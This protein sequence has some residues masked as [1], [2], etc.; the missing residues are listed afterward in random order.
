M[1]RKFIALITATLLALSPFCLCCTALSDFSGY[2]AV[3]TPEELCRLMKNSSEWGGSFYLTADIDLSGSAGQNPIGTDAAHPFTGIFDG[4]GHTVKGLDIKASPAAGLFGCISGAQIRNLTVQG[5]VA[6]TFEAQNA[7]TKADGSYPGSGA[8]AGIV[9]TG[10]VIENCVSRAGVSAPGNCGGLIGVIYNYGDFS[11]KV[12]DCSNYG[13]VNTTLG[14]A[15]ALIGRIQAACTAA[16]AVSVEGCTN[17]ADITSLSPDR[18]RVGGI[19]GYVRA[20]KG[21]I[22]IADC[23]NYGSISGSN[24]AT[25]ASHYPYAGGITGRIEIVSDVSSSVTVSGC[26]NRGKITSSEIAG[27]ITAYISCGKTCI[28]SVSGI[29]GCCNTA[30]VS[31]PYTA[32]GIAGLT[33]NQNTDTENRVTVKNCMNCGDISS[34]DSAG[35]I[36]GVN[37]AVD[38]IYCFDSSAVTASGLAGYIEGKADGINSYVITGCYAVSGAAGLALSGYPGI[39][40]VLSDAKL[41]SPAEA[42]L[43]AT[44]SGYD[45]NGVWKIENGVPVLS[46]FSSSAPA[47]TTSPA[48]TSPQAVPG[49]VE[50]DRQSPVTG[51]AVP[52]IIAAAT[53]AAACQAIIIGKKPKSTEFHGSQL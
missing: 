7:E 22:V 39:A 9:L 18:C 2:T 11:V 49:T 52:F 33:A 30:E 32:G 23:G 15:G 26:I 17:Y 31:G 51:S 46:A 20:E 24:E 4:N 36:I 12:T 43:E 16:S 19:A 5:S 6:N 1:F 21:S 14:N 53:A 38:L 42:A 45:F 47:V 35:G 10:S 41:I 44:F 27:G 50:P 3:S 48:V 34:T 37:T 8:V 29:F 25:N 13:I 28:G 40:A